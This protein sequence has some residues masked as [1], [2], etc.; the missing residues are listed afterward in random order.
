MNLKVKA[1]ILVI[2]HKGQVG[3]FLF[4]CLFGL[5][6]GLQIGDGLKVCIFLLM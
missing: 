1:W 5:T 3:L 4:V 6:E 2:H